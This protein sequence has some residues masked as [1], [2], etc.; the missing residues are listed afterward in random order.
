M[1]TRPGDLTSNIVAFCRTLRSDLG[2][3][4]GQDEA[5][6]ALRAVEVVGMRDVDRVRRAMRLVLC[7]KPEEGQAFDAAFDL[8]FRRPDRGIRQN[9]YAPRHT[10]DAQG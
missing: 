10:R 4:V 8:F 9:L 1:S 6:D 2:F 5:H 7:T 3:H